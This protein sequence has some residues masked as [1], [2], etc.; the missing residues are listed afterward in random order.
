M[1]FKCKDCEKVYE[2]GPKN[3]QEKNGKIETHLCAYCQ[4][5]NKMEQVKEEMA[6]FVPL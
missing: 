5:C 4:K 6:D 2:A 3:I 1:K